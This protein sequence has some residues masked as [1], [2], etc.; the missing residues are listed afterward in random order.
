MS[1][2]WTD[3]LFSC[4]DNC[5][6]C[7]LSFLLP[8]YVVGK[9]GESLGKNFCLICIGMEVPVWNVMLRVKIRGEIR[10]MQDIDG[11]MCNDFLA[12]IFCPCCSITQEAKEIKH[13]FGDDEMARE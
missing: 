6:I 8:C 13:I 4:F 2:E 11:T 5:G 10:G 9:N 1:S 7:I 3:S 12:I